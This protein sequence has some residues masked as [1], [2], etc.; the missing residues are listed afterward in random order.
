MATGDGEKYCLRWND[1]TSNLSSAFNEL[2]DDEDF[3]DITLITEESEIRCHKLILGACSPHFRNIIRRLSA[4]QNPAIYLRGVRHED[5]KNI[6]EFMYLGMVNV[7]QEDLDSFLSVAQDLCIKGLTQDGGG[8]QQSQSQTSSTHQTPSASAS[9]SPMKHHIANTP[10]PAKRAKL[11]SNGDN[12]KSSQAVPKK[13]P[14]KAEPDIVQIDETSGDQGDMEGYEDY[15]GGEAGPSDPG[16]DGKDMWTEEPKELGLCDL[17]DGSTMCLKCH[18]KYGSRVHAKTH[19]KE[20]HQ[21]DR[22]ERCHFCPICQKSFA[23][24]RYMV[25]HM[26]T[27]HGVSQKM[28]KNTYL[29]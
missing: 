14:I 16:D 22:N 12:F 18:K 6:L 15:Y 8:N 10:P 23:V 17:D 24:Q 5:I 21:V 28:Y 1:F 25:N 3:F 26:K 9:N 7:A 4:V 2:R 11:K 20:V 27:I 29:P 19:F 13:E